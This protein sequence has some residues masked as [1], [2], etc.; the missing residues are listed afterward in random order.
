MLVGGAGG[1]KTAVRNILQKALTLLPTVV[2]EGA[3]VSET[4]ERI[5]GIRS[6]RCRLDP[7]DRRL[8]M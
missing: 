3:L 2:K 4:E 7:V 6:I 1:G 5:E 8:L